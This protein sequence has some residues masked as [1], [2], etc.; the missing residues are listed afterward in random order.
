VELLVG[1]SGLAPSV[2]DYH[3]R[4]ALHL[5]AANGHLPIVQFLVAQPVRP[6]APPP[7]FALCAPSKG[8]F[9]LA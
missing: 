4:T 8:G 7:A 9:A 5:A 6:A 2:A 1:S 3:G